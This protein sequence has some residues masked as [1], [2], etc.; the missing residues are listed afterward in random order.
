M[1]NLL[2]M[3]MASLVGGSTLFFAPLTG[4]CG[5]AD[6]LYF[7]ADAGGNVTEDIKLLEFF[8]PAADGFAEAA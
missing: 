6:G 4:S 1:K 7:K 5:P 2:R 8:G 3:V